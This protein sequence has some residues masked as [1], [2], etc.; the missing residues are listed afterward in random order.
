MR[1]GGKTKGKKG[2]MRMSK[3]K[4]VLILICLVVIILIAV[5]YMN[6]GKRKTID[7][8]RG[9]VTMSAQEIN[10]N[11]VEKMAA[12]LK[13]ISRYNKKI[14]KEKRSADSEV[15][16]DARITR[17]ERAKKVLDE[18][19]EGEKKDLVWKKKIE[20][21]AQEI[22]DKG[23]YAGT[24]LKKVDCGMTICKMELAFESEEKRTNFREKTNFVM[25]GPWATSQFGGKIDSSENE[26]GVY[27]YFSREGEESL[28]KRVEDQ[29]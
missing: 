15:G 11:K 1:C 24:T 27:F 5:T 26:P 4:S 13:E 9:E 28:L 3:K 12:Q 6:Y 18:M 22:L 29:K 21:A 19:F 25:E 16:G 14:T 20:E 17:M 10:R 7:S 8:E 23:E 2:A